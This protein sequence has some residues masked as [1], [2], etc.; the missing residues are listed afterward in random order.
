MKY[1]LTPLA[2]IFFSSL[3]LAQQQELHISGKIIDE[4]RNAIPF[5]NAA[6]YNASDSSLVTGAFSDADGK[7]QIGIK[8]GT[9]YMKITFLSYEEKTIPDIRIID[10]N[11]S[12]GSII[13][14]ATSDVLEEIVITGKKEAMELQLDKRVFNV[15]KD[16]SNI[17]ANASDILGNL[18]SVT[19]DVDGSVSLRGS[20]NVTI[21]INGRPSS[22]TSRDPDALRKLQGNM[23]ESI[24]VITNPSSRYDAAGEVGII[25]IILKKS[26]ERGFNGSFVANAGYPTLFGGSYSLNYR[27]K[28]LN[29]FSSYG[30]D[31]RRSPGNGTSFQ[32]YTSADTSFAYTQNNDRSRGELSH[33]FRLGLDYFLNDKNSITGSFTYNTSDGLNTATAE[34]LDYDENDFI[35]NTTLRTESEAED[36]KNIELN[37]NYTKDF[38]QKGRKLTTDFQWIKS[39]DNESTDYNQLTNE[40]EIIAQRSVNDANESN[41]LFQSDYIQPFSD[42]SKFEAGV[43]TTTRVIKN[44]Y[45][46]EQQDEDMNWIPFDAFTNNLVYTERIHAAYAMASTKINKIA[47]QGGLRGELSDITTE[48]TA[49]NELNKQNYFKLFP[50]AA[51]SYELKK[52]NT[53]QLSYSYRISRPRFRDLIPF[54]NFSNPRVFFGGNPNLRPE[55]T[56]AYEV[57]Y[58]LEWS[59][60]SVLSSVYHRHR[61]DVIQRITEIQEDGVARIMPI[62]LAKQ[63]AYGIEFNLSYDILPWWKFNTSANFF[64]AITEGVYQEEDL[65]SDTYSWRNRTTSKMTFFGNLDFQ[66]SFNYRAP[67]VTTQGKRLSSYSIDLGLSRDVLNGK[68]TI[69]AGVRDLMNSNKRRY[70]ID[71]Q[72]Y[73]SNS[74]FQWR[75]R[76]FTVSFSYRLNRDKERQRDRSSGGE[77]EEF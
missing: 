11:I 17:G 24:E 42:D 44:E 74:E 31:K 77:D 41:W 40:T 15:G 37:F 7:F 66:V 46:F 20:E 60:G 68:G 69:T 38:K 73:N 34:Y 32:Q 29:F 27:N 2:L 30:I 18:P 1:L 4:Q 45:I 48:L 13:L 39:V 8:A 63:N 6:V 62:N 26:Q 16:L 14:K 71:T 75:Q 43:K 12:L 67:Q 64:R 28:N 56:H 72:G 10:K 21:W 23:I 51:L 9:Y 59:K 57:G 3:L 19:V 55:Y 22:L 5:G 25:N 54:S 61:T 36:E 52:N 35:T 50:S 65:F 53:L 58:L 70:I 49:T 47:I 33:N 76:Q